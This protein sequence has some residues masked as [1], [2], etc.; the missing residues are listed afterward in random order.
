MAAFLA[1]AF[2]LA[3]ATIPVLARVAAFVVNTLSAFATA[4]SYDEA[5]R[6]QEAASN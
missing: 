4:R 1:F 6:E 3:L 2:V 5:T